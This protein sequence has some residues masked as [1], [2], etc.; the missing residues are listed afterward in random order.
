MKMEESGREW[1]KK[2]VD[3]QNFHLY[4]P[5]YSDPPTYGYPF[6]TP[7]CLLYIGVIFVIDL[8]RLCYCQIQESAKTL[9]YLEYMEKKYK[10]YSIDTCFDEYAIEFKLVG[11]ESVDDLLSHLDTVV[12]YKRQ[13]KKIV[14]DKD[15]RISEIPHLYT[16]TPYV[17]LDCYAYCE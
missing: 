14:R 13:V 16:D 9:L 8:P 5:F 12:E 2:V 4:H 7:L 11:A 15:W 3:V 10:V 6:D 1:N 17:V